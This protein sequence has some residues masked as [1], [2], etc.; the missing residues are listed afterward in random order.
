MSVAYVSPYSDPPAIRAQSSPASQIG[1]RLSGLWADVTAHARS[2]ASDWRPLANALIEEIWQEC[3]SPS[4]DGYGARAVPIGAK[5]RAQR[6]VD[7]LPYRLPAPDPAA[8]PDGDVSLLW[9]FGPGHVFSVS[10]SADGTLT[11]AGLLGGGVKRHGVEPF[12]GNI[13]KIILQSIDELC[14]RS[15]VVSHDR[16]D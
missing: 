6:F 12:N 7:L 10:V 8:D 11:Y 3:Q 14:E 16:A 2:N 9:D 5:T 4:W 15:G 1:Q 13:P